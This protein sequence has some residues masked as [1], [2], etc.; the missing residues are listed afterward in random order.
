MTQGH[1]GKEKCCS[2]YG[3]RSF[4][5]KGAVTNT[6]YSDKCREG[7]MTKYFEFFQTVVNVSKFR[8]YRNQMAEI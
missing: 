7:R 4:K 8:W 1:V 3:E 2:T 5:N 6:K